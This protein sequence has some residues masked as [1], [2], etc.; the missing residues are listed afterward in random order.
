MDKFYTVHRYFNQACAILH[1]KPELLVNEDDLK[2]ILS[3]KPI[4]HII[5]GLRAAGM[6][7]GIITE[8]KKVPSGTLVVITSNPKINIS[9]TISM[10]ENRFGKF[11]SKLNES[12][13]PTWDYQQK[14]FQ[15]KE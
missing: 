2:V 11:Y 9:S 5:N 13:D 15:V 4:P 7:N 6:A 14:V 3:P 1:I 8:A 10:V 12:F